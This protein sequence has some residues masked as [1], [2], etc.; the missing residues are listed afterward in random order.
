MNGCKRRKWNSR[1]QNLDSNSE[2]KITV[3]SHRTLS[4]QIPEMSKTKKF[5]FSFVFV[6]PLF[7]RSLICQ[8]L[9]TFASVSVPKKRSQF[10][11]LPAL[12]QKTISASVGLK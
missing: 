8:K 10:A 2:L 5:C 11:P 12:L 6:V 7:L 3:G 4:E 1:S 9:I